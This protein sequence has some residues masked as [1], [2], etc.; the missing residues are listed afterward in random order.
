VAAGI[1]QQFQEFATPAVSSVRAYWTPHYCSLE[2]RINV[3]TR[4]PKH[5]TRNAN[6]ETR[7][8]EPENRNPKP[9][10]LYHKPQT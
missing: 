3:E 1:L 6:P 9:V 2:T 5:E 8:P 4:T 10:K 7:N